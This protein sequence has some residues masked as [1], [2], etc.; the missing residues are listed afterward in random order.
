MKSISQVDDQG[1]DTKQDGSIAQAAKKAL[2]LD[3]ILIALG[4][5]PYVE[6]PGNIWSPYLP[7]G[8]HTLQ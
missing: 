8:W 7:E 2:E 1:Q 5:E 3:V 6:K 4:Q